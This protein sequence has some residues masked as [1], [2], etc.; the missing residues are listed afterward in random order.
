METVTFLRNIRGIRE[1]AFE[2]CE[3]LYSISIPSTCATISD[4]AFSCCYSLGS[5]NLSN[6]LTYLG[7]G[8]CR[9]C[10]NLKSVTIPFTINTI[11]SQT[12]F[13]CLTLKNE[14]C[15]KNESYAF[16]TCKAIET[17]N[18]P[19]LVNSIDAYCFAYAENLKSKRKQIL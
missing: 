14:R 18:I 2:Y 10:Q 19:A 17:I 3:G 4:R 5:I 8:A 9:Y 13:Y 7:G 1:S 12:F 15:Q 6:G 11:H 16:Q